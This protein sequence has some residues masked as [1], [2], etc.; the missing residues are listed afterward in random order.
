[1]KYIIKIKVTGKLP[2]ESLH[3]EDSR[4]QRTKDIWTSVKVMRSRSKYGREVEGEVEGTLKEV[5]P[6][7]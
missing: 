2:R 5:Q 6:E 7:I 3:G 4:K 1:M